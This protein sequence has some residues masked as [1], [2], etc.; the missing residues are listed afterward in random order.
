[1]AERMFSGCGCEQCRW[2]ED[3]E[4][5]VTGRDLQ[6]RGAGSATAAINLGAGT[7]EPTGA[8]RNSQPARPSRAAFRRRGLDR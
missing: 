6:V 8:R 7:A 1:M 5:I 2:V 4:D 3:F